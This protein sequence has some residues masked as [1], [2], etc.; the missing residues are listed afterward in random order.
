[1]STIKLH[2]Q[3]P[4]F[5]FSFSIVIHLEMQFLRNCPNILQKWLHAY[6]YSSGWELVLSSFLPV[7]AIV[8]SFNSCNLVCGWWHTVI[9][10][11][12]FLLLN[13]L[14]S[15]S[16]TFWSFV[17]PFDEIAFNNLFYKS[18]PYWVLRLICLYSPVS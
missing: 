4:C 13:I 18:D 1:M 15:F 8:S 2:P 6:F 14:S 16:H 3:T 10:I 5:H 9:L 12:I 7:F 17:S 11:C